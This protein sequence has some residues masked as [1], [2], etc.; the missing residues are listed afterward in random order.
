MGAAWLS[1]LTQCDGPVTDCIKYVC[2]GATCHSTC[3][4]LCELD[5]AN[6]ATEIADDSAEF[7][8]EAG[9]WSFHGKT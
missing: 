8:L 6:P 9:D 3:C 5:I 7:S 1:A 4:D 2:N